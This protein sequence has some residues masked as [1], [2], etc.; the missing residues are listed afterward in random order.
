MNR[1]LPIAALAVVPALRAS[2]GG[3]PCVPVALDR[4]LAS[5]IPERCSIYLEATGLLPLFEQGLEHPFLRTLRT[6]ELVQAWLEDVSMSPEDALSRADAWLSASVL[7]AA[8]G[9]S[10]RG[11]ALAQRQQRI[12]EV[13]PGHGKTRLGL[14]G[15]LESRDR[16]IKAF[17]V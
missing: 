3:E 6:S 8:A 4:E 7:E 16:L 13:V 1:L 5:L 15:C 9:L 10:K 12:S 2:P 11:L 14:G 17:E